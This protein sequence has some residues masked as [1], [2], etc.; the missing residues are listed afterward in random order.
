MM[1]LRHLQRQREEGDQSGAITAK[2]IHSASTD[3]RLQHP[4]IDLA[5]IDQTTELK[6]ITVA[7]AAGR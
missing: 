4:A 5:Q 6:Q 7:S 2:L 3:Q 1:L